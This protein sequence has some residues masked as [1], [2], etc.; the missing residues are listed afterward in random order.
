MYVVNISLQIWDA[1]SFIQ[2]EREYNFSPV[3]KKKNESDWGEKSLALH[4]QK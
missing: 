3:K 2:M 4:G 1:L